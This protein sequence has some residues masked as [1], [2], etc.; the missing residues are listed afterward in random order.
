MRMAKGQG[1]FKKWGKGSM[2]DQIE[3]QETSGKQKTTKL[4]VSEWSQ[5]LLYDM[6]NGCKDLHEIIANERAKRKEK[7]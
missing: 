1:R 4:P 5:N 2:C 6:D 3:K 7:Q